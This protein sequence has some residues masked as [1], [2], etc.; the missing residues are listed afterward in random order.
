MSTFLLSWSPKDLNW[1]TFDEDID[2]L[3]NHG[4][5]LKEWYI[6]NEEKIRTGD[7]FFLMLICEEYKGIIASGYFTSEPY[8]KE[9]WLD[10]T[11]IQFMV[12]IDFDILINH[13]K[14]WTIKLEEL[15]I[16]SEEKFCWTSMNSGIIIPA[17]LAFSLEEEWFL[18]LNRICDVTF[19]HFGNHDSRVE[20]MFENQ[21]ERNPYARKISQ[22][23]R[24]QSCYVCGITFTEIGELSCSEIMEYHQDQ[25]YLNFDDDTF[26]YPED[27]LYPVCPNCHAMIHSRSYP[28]S[29]EELREL[30]AGALSKS[31]T[32]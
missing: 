32:K 23:Q 5:L 9:E 21:Y 3:V 22:E 13:D 28:Y 7:R 24:G 31:K 20:K 10:K 4:H 1:E 29:M 26:G 11:A 2:K 8:I 12:N 17:D 18:L 6:R 16:L 19:I 27:D 25:E 14:H 15:K 30:I